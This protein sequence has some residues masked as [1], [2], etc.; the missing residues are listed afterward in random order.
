MTGAAGGLVLA[1]RW[2]N[3]GNLSMIYPSPLHNSVSAPSTPLPA[4][5]LA[6]RKGFWGWLLRLSLG[7][8]ILAALVVSGKLDL[9]VLM[10][11]QVGAP[12]GILLG[13][14]VLALGANSLRWVCLVQTMGY[15]IP[16]WERARV[17]LASN[18]FLFISPAG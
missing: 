5:K 9:W 18:V 16:A 2:C 15:D 11:V 17:A 1:A 8:I 3:C 12:L 6:Q 10:K 4:A 7:V 13:V 14:C